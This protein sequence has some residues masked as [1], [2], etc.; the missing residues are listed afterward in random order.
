[1]AGERAGDQLELRVPRL[2]GVD[3]EAALL[4]RIGE[5]CERARHLRVVGK[6]LVETR[7]DA[8]RRP[9]LD[10]REA[11]PIERVGVDEAR[12]VRQV[13]LGDERDA[14]ATLMSL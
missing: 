4:Q 10:R 6:Q 7:R 5:S 14:T 12:D 13:H 8:D 2:S 3:E 9:R 11:R 1:M